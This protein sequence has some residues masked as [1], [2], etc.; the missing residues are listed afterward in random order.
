MDQG[1]IRNFIP[2][3]LKLNY[4]INPGS[5]YG[6]NA[7]NAGLAIGLATLVT[8]IALVIFIFANDKK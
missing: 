5:A 2:H 6:A 4:M 3:F 7:S 1:E 8:M